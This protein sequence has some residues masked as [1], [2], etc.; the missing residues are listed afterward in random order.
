[1]T[2]GERLA[3]LAGF[4]GSA[5]A[6]LL[7]IGTGATAGELLVSRS[8]LET[9]TAAEHLLAENTPVVVSTQQGGSGAG[10]GGKL[11]RQVGHFGAAKP[12]RDGDG[13]DV[14]Y[15]QFRAEILAPVDIEADDEEVVML[16][17]Q[18]LGEW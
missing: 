13:Y 12:G 11:S 4:S 15:P 7:A 3:Q 10:A 18:M 14:D 16:L 6:L 2:A 17:V 8:G 9:G 1:M 5:A